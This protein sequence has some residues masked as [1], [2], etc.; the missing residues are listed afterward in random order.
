MLF[1]ATLPAQ[2]ASHTHISSAVRVPEYTSV[3]KFS[4]VHTHNSVQLA[5][6]LYILLIKS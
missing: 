1:L 3:T 2:A 5:L 4:T 6:G